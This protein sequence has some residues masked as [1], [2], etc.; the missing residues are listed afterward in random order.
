MA[1]FEFS[2]QTRVQIGVDVGKIK[3]ELMYKSLIIGHISH[4]RKHWY[5]DIVN[6]PWKWKRI[7]AF[8]DTV[9]RYPDEFY[10]V[11]FVEKDDDDNVIS[12]IMGMAQQ[13]DEHPSRMM[14]VED[15][16]AWIRLPVK[17]EDKP[18]IDIANAL[19]HNAVPLDGDGLEIEDLETPI[20]CRRSIPMTSDEVREGQFDDDGFEDSF[21]KELAKLSVPVNAPLLPLL[22]PPGSKNH[23][24]TLLPPTDEEAE[25]EMITVRFILADEDDAHS[26]PAVE[27]IPSVMNDSIIKH[28]EHTS[29]NKAM[30]TALSKAGI[31]TIGQLIKK[32]P[33]QILSIPRCGPSRLQCLVDLMTRLNVKW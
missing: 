22:P 29:S 6:I 13:L 4:A 27:D 11:V 14:L 18:T 20:K 12:L 3:Y 26:A 9:I 25:E 28:L 5:V 2:R 15:A 33:E 7:N 31:V 24:E 21:E 10:N 30:C 17:S 19:I 8:C 1:K 32:T 16:R 23:I